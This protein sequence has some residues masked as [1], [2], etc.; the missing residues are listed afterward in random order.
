MAKDDT[1]VRGQLRMFLSRKINK[2]DIYPL[3]WPLYMKFEINRYKVNN[4][5]ESRHRGEPLPML[6]YSRPQCGP[7]G[8]DFV[9]I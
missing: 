1:A 7:R 9:M 5:D 6:Q 3:R 8:D 2:T 4:V